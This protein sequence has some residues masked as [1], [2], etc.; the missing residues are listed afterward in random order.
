ML[1]SVMHQTHFKVNQGDIYVVP[2][3][4]FRLPLHVGCRIPEAYN[5]DSPYT[6]FLSSHTIHL[7]CVWS[8]GM[9]ILKTEQKGIDYV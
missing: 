2:P 1:L 6:H 7:L 8:P 5:R 3:V 9:F 4:M